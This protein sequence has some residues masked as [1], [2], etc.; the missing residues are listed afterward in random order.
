MK[1]QTPSGEERH[2]QRRGGA[3][4]D[5]APVAYVAALTAV[6]IA[7]TIIPLPLSIVIGFGRSFPL[8]QGLYG[9][10]GWLLG[11]LAGALANGIGVLIGIFVNPQ[12]TTIPG[13]S[14]AGAAMG[15]L[16]AGVLGAMGLRRRWTLPLALFFLLEYLLYGGRAIVHNGADVR[17]VLAGSFI[18]WSALLL[19]ILPTRA[20]CARWLR[21][22]DLRYVTVGLFIGTWISSGLAHLTS[23]TWVYFIYNW[24][25]ENWWLMAPAAP[26]EHVAR[27]VIGAIVGTGVIA[28]LRATGI[29][30]P[31]HAAY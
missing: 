20:L 14:V 9:L 29:L 21:H 30:K 19:F 3:T 17:A 4:I 8:S 28:G 22:A 26:V 25:A 16:A 27:C 11:P 7:F 1:L 6:M 5:G 18:N 10:V 12:N 23:A 15:A 31:L 24:P 13:A 2:V